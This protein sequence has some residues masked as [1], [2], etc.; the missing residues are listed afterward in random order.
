MNDVAAKERVELL[1]G[2]PTR[3]INRELSWLAFNERVLEEADNRAPSA[4]GAAALPVDLGQ[5]PR[6][7]LH[8]ARRRPAR[9]R[10]RP[11]SRRS[12]QDGL[13]PAQ[14]L[15]AIHERAGRADAEPAGLLAARCATSCA[16]A[17]IAVVDAERARPPTTAPGSTSDFIDRDLPGAD[18]ARDRPGAPVPVH[19]QPR[20]RRSRSS[21][22]ARDGGAAC[23]RC[24]PLPSQ[25]ARFV[26]L[27]RRRRIRFLPLE[28]LVALFL[29]RLFPGFDRRRAWAIFR[30]LRDSDIEIEEEAEDLVRLFE[31]GAEAAPARQ[32]HPAHGRC[33]ACRS[34]LRAFVSERA[35]RRA[36]R[37]GRAS[38]ACS[39]SPT[40]RS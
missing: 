14:Q 30:V 24:V 8:G 28:E 35:R 5:Q 21:C 37:R 3:F 7:V 16:T 18:A 25:L 34:E 23:R 29:D 15:D 38:T 11:A 26:R 22:S 17:G 33:G 20:L 13:T 9:A 40:P 4:A 2:S 39:A 10:S 12:S 19:P 31:I 36:E 27:P 1:A 6:R 32:R